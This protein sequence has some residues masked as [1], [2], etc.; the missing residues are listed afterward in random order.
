MIKIPIGCLQL[1]NILAP[2]PWKEI[3]NDRELRRTKVLPAC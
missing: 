1:I 2:K 3:L